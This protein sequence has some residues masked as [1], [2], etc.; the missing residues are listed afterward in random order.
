VFDSGLSNILFCVD[1]CNKDAKEY[2]YSQDKRRKETKSKKYGKILLEQ[3][4]EKIDK[5]T[6]IE[7]ETE[8]CKYNRKTLDIEKFKLKLESNKYYIGKTNNPNFRLNQHFTSDGCAWTKK[9]KPIKL[10][11]IDDKES[12]QYFIEYLKIGNKF[13]KKENIVKC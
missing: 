12:Y 2:R 1:D 11:S 3:K 7:L 5:K 6:I 8:L 13:E 9:Y 4:Q 10:M